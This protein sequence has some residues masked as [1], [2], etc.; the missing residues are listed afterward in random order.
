MRKIFYSLFVFAGLALTSCSENNDKGH[1]EHGH[2]HHEGHE[3]HEGHD[4]EGH[5]HEG[6]EHGEHAH[7]ETTEEAEKPSFPVE[8]YEFYGM[9]E[10]KPGEAVTVEE[11]VAKIHADGSFDGNV[12]AVLDG[13]CKKM[14]CWVTMVNKS[15]ESV[16]VRF[17]DHEFGVPTDTPEGTEVVLRGIG[18]MDTTSVELQKHYLDDAKEAGQEVAQEQYDAI[19]EDLIEISF[20]SD[21]ILV[22]K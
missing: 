11:M 12:S 5:D 19:T 13:V 6:H 17:K 3:G 7:H 14:G 15:G 1:D 4:H 21:G 22:K 18:T 9:A 10:V 2:E 16:R 8:G 20:I